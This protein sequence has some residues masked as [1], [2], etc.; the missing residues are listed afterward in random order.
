MPT[1]IDPQPE[2]NEIECARCGAYFFYELSR[3]PQCGVNIYEPE[4]EADKEFRSQ[5][6]TSQPSKGGLFPKI[7]G[8]LKRRF[9]KSPLADEL[10]RRALDQQALYEELLRK[11]GGDRA[12]ADRLIQ[13]ERGYDPD[14][15]R[16]V[17]L[18]NAIWRWERDNR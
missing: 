2:E 18:Q 7:V 15:N 12:V 5:S 16:S 11:V 1:S 4:D 6:I 9:G 3:C 13:Y 17:W 8:A 14:A 10:F